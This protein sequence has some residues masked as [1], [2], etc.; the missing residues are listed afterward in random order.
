[1]TAGQPPRGENN[2]TPS[3]VPFDCFCGVFRAGRQEAAGGRQQWRYEQFIA[4]H[5]SA[6]GHARHPRTLLPFHLI[7]PARRP[8]N[9]PRGVR[10][11]RQ[12]SRM[13]AIAIRFTNTSVQGEPGSW[14]YWAAP[15]TGRATINEPRCLAGTTTKEKSER[16]SGLTTPLS[17]EIGT[18]W[19]RRS[20]VFAFGA[21]KT[22]PIQI[23]ICSEPEVALASGVV[24][25]LSTLRRAARGTI[26]TRA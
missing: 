11:R 4:A 17:E 25:L 8:T 15:A 26:L 1:M 23:L 6:Q 24:P 18:G 16:T 21:A 22:P 3:T 20:F 13:W 5:R 2:A 10:R 9:T 7:T 19:A 14:G 12:G